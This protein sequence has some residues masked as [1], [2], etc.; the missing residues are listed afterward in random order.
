MA[1]VGIVT[2]STSALPTELIKEYNIQVL[3]M[4]VV[5]EDKPYRDDGEPRSTYSQA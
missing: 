4:T 2:Y 3:P 1:K 5:I